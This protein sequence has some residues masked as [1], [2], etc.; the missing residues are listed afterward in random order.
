MKNKLKVFILVLAVF[1]AI[2][3]PAFAAPA[4]EQIQTQGQ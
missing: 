4:D 2:S 3:R 1:A